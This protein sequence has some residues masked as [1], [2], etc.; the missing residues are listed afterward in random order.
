MD[1]LD[2]LLVCGNYKSWLVSC[3]IYIY[4]LSRNYEKIYLIITRKLSIIVRKDPVVTRKDHIVKK[5]LSRYH[6]KNYLVITRKD[7]VVTREDFVVMGKLSR[8]HENR[9]RN[10]EKTNL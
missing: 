1:V 3:F 6:E 10:Y 2:D 7:P 9:S 5:K 8:Y 4:F